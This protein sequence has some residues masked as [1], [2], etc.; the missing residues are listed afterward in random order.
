MNTALHSLIKLREQPSVASKPENLLLLES[1][2]AR[3]QEIMSTLIQEKE[4]Y[5][6]EVELKLAKLHEHY[7][8]IV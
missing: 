7:S 3:L 2:V 5:E 1:V 6:L 4:Q 8:Q